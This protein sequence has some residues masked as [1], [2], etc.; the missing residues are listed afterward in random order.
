MKRIIRTRVAHERLA[1][2]QAIALTMFL[3]DGVSRAETMAAWVELAGPDGEPSVRV[4]TDEPNC[5]ALHTNG[6][7]V[8][9]EVRARP[10]RL[11]NGDGELPPAEFNVTVCEAKPGRGVSEVA[12]EGRALPIPRAKINRIVIVGDTGCRIKGKKTQD[13]DDP[14]EWPYAK[15]A[16]QAA[17]AK[18]DLVIHVGD[19]L[20]REKPC[21][22]RT[23]C[24]VSKTGYD[25]E[26]W[27]EDFFDP[28]APLLAAA[29][30]IMVRGN[31]ETC[32]R[33]GEGWFRFLDGPKPEST[34]PK[35]SPS[36]VT[37]L[38]GLGFL[39]MDSALVADAGGG[40]E[41][42]D[43]GD[44]PAL[45]NKPDLEA[46]LLQ[47]FDAHKLSGD[48]WLLTHVPFNGIRVDKDTGENEVDNSILQDSV[49]NALPPLIQMIVSGHI[50]LFEALSFSDTRPPQLVVGTSGD[51]LAKRPKGLDQFGGLP[52]AAR[53]VILKRFGYMV[54]YREEMQAG[55]WKGRLF[56]ENGIGLVHCDLKLKAL[57]C[58]EEH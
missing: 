50:H 45:T 32:R 39:V 20:Y 35:V 27:K 29:P 4:V 5:P 41:D 24:P 21:R 17:D 40:D 3:Y 43:D 10:G 6:G 34:C 47:S 15:V 36:W 1:A 8:P 37:N 18:P 19:Y 44:S 16:Q 23:A 30:W 25:W 51:K 22:D 52:T 7:P 14:E 53:P 57:D 33:A 26:V 31:H 2:L 13:C 55:Q 28:S 46:A 11:F 54:W 42:E 58:T 12:V 56:D 49:G 48:A 38:G 9:M